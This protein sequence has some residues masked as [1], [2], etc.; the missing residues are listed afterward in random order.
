MARPISTAPDISPLTDTEEQDRLAMKA[1]FVKDYSI[2]SE[3]DLLILDL[4]SY[5][6]CKSKRLQNQELTSGHILGNIRF[7]PISELVRLLDMMSAT[8]R[9][10]IASKQPASD[11]QDEALRF[12]MDY[13]EL[14]TR[15]NGHV[16]QASH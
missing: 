8:R 2:V 5:E 7:H 6:Y 12:F 3:S 4:A 10:K 1:A 14:P 11:T 13:S 9:A 16:K 15:S